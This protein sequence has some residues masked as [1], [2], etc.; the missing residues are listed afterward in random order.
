VLTGGDDYEIV[1]TIPPGKLDHFRAAADAVRVPVTEIGRIV[2]PG[3]P[4]RFLAQDGK[5]MTFKQVS[6]SHF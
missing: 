2:E 1:C 4:P 6:F 5:A 3:Q